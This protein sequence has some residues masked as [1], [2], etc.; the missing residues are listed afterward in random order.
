MTVSIAA[1]PS[2][3]HDGPGGAAI[4]PLAAHR[5]DALQERYAQL[6]GEPADLVR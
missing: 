6:G 3:T 4:R 2:R 1:G 5:M